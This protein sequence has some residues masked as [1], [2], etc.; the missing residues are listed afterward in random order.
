MS[1]YSIFYLI[2]WGLLLLGGAS[3][4]ALFFFAVFGSTRF[5]REPD[6]SILWKLFLIGIVG[7]VIIFASLRC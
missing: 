2:G 7:A 3:G 1:V 5:S 4:V 6:T